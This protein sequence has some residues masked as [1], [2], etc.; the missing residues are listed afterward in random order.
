[1][2]YLADATA[3]ARARDVRFKIPLS[4]LYSYINQK[5]PPLSLFYVPYFSL[6]S[7]RS[8][9]AIKIAVMIDT[10][11]LVV[12]VGPAGAALACFLGQNGMYHRRIFFIFII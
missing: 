2:R 11:F 7:S 1:M 8:R 5:F 6:H 9:K 4:V 3:A 10:D 12:G